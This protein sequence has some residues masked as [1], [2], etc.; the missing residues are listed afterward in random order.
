MVSVWLGPWDSNPA[1]PA[2]QADCL[3]NWHRPQYLVGSLR[4]ELSTG[5]P[6]SPVLPLHQQP[7]IKRLFIKLHYYCSTFI[8]ANG[9]SINIVNHSLTI[10]LFRSTF[11]FSY[12]SFVNILYHKFFIFSNAVIRFTVALLPH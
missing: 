9:L 2:Y 12:L 7:H 8:Y 1:L 3:T 4:V 10:E 6:Q 11:Y 5:E